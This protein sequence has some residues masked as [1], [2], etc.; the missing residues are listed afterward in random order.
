LSHRLQFTPSL[1]LWGGNES[2]GSL[3]LNAWFGMPAPFNQFSIRNSNTFPIQES[4][5]RL[6]LPPKAR[7]PKRAK[8]LK[9]TVIVRPVRSVNFYDAVLH[10]MVLEVAV[11]GHNSATFSVCELGYS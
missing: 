9:K 7:F 8:D 6:A 1:W 10:L 11:Y 5:P 3:G 4:A 2:N